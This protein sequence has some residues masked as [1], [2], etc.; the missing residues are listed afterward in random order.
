MITRRSIARG[1]RP[2]RAGGRTLPLHSRA[3]TGQHT[4]NSGH[5][6]QAQ[7]LAA[8]RQGAGGL[9]HR[10]R[11]RRSAVQGEPI[12]RASVGASV[13]FEPGART[14]WHTHP[15]G[16]TLIVTSGLR[17]GA[18]RRRPDRGN[19]AGRHRLVP[20]GEKHWHGAT[21]TTAM[22]HIAIA[23][24]CRLT[25]INP[26]DPTLLNFS[27]AASERRASKASALM[28]SR[29]GSAI[30]CGTRIRDPLCPRFL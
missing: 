29:P 10:H 14:A 22:A 23:A 4:E 7:R 5:G 21:P 26:S 25:K 19:P 20:P 28:S 15:L 1:R 3:A 30:S 9:F 17:L 24:A 27:I 6:N 18:A 2:R 13:T 11:A 12:R 8:V 16:Q